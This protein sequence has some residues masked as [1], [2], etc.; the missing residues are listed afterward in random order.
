MPG[1]G[2]SGFF[3]DV[4]DSTNF[5]VSFIGNP[6]RDF[7]IFARGY[8]LA[9]QTLSESILQRGHFPDYEA[10]PIVFLYRHSLELYLKGLLIE[11]GFLVAFRGED[12]VD[13]KFKFNHRL[14]ILANTFEMVY[15]K[16]FPTDA[17]LHRV[18]GEVKIVASDLEL[19]DQDSLSY[20]YPIN[21]QGTAA[22]EHHQVV[23]L[24][25]LHERMKKLLDDL[26]TI[27]FGMDLET[28][29]AQEFYEV[30]VEA[31]NLL[32]RS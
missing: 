21:K 26:D 13:A 22:T 6:Q 2:K 28:S 12:D 29:Q 15:R 31:R 3:N 30:L 8:S 17:E 4:G 19:L 7:G 14:G 32:L 9:G 24:R 18:L 11:A 23:N 10:Y 16:L 1:I 25:A 27:D 5:R 20:R